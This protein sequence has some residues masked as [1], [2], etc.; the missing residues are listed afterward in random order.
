MQHLHTLKKYGLTAE[1]VA[2]MFEAKSGNSFRSSSA[3]K[4]HMRAADKIARF[5]EEAILTKLK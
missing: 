3:Y 4:R 5:V 1:K 2:E